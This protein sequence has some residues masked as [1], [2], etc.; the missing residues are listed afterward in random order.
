[1]ANIIE[2]RNRPDL[3]DLHMSNGLT[4]M[5]IYV[6]V[7]AASSLAANVRQA[8]LA[9]WLASRDQSLLG[10]GI[11]GFD[12]EDMP[13]LS[14]GFLED[15]QFLIASV[16]AALK[17]K[18][19]ERINFAPKEDWVFESLAQFRALLAAFSPQHVTP[20]Q[21]QDL[22]FGQELPLPALCTLHRV[23][24]HAHGCVICNDG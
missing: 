7:L 12:L 13:W 24:L 3:A 6:M 15:Q 4:S 16:D 20:A 9:A 10:G 23:Y 21:E 19:W 11:V 22:P 14:D 18:G 8:Q 5:F 2:Y 17:R 1:M